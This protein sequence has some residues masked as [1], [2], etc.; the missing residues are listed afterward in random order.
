MYQGYIL[1]WCTIA[2]MDQRLL[3]TRPAQLSLSLDAGGEGKK[4]AWLSQLPPAN[5]NIYVC[6]MSSAIDIVGTDDD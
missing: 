1:R 5:P 4:A 2:L 6:R 3:R